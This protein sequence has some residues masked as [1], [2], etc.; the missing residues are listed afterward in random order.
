[1]DHYYAKVD[2]LEDRFINRLRK[3]I[4]IPSISAYASHRSDV[5]A[6][7]EFIIQEMTALGIEGRLRPLGKEPNTDLDLPPLVIGR[8]G[9]DPKKPTI[10]VYSHYDVQP[11]AIEDGW[12]RNPWD[13]TIE[14]DGT[15]HGRGTSDDKGPLLAWLNAIEAF[16]EAGVEVPANLVFCFEGMEENGSTGFRQTLEEEARTSLAD[17]DAV[18]ITDT[19][20]GGNSHPSIT[21]GLRGV[22]FY[23]LTVTG[24]KRDAHSGLFG[25]HLSEPMTDV[26]TLM[27]SLVDSTGR[28]LVPGIYEGV[29]EVSNSERAAIETLHLSAED[30]DP[31]LGGRNL[32]DSI[33]DTIIARSRLPS[34]SLHRIE[35]AMPGAGAVT[36]IP[37]KVQGKFSIRTVADMSAEHVNRLVKDHIKSE[38]KSLKSVNSAELVCV[39]KSNWFFEDVDHWNYQ[40]AKM[41]TK[42]VWNKEPDITCEGG[43]IPIALDLKE[44]LGKNVLLLPMGKPSDG[45]HSINEKLDKPN[46]LNGIKLFGS[47]LNQVSLLYS[48]NDAIRPRGFK[49]AEI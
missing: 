10:L 13:L 29:K 1:M 24:A 15:L 46:Y 36:S 27:S 16:Q 22:L 12:D 6:M 7:A 4:R 26:A 44:V 30:V 19:T 11:A 37:A 49:A 41:A 5:F 21:R 31:G 32:H 45:A 35:N 28:I 9:K 39:H 38:F 34:L 3:G 43:S 20:W 33:A 17:I 8:Y 47:Y 40:A 2:E 42:A 14:A 25:G 48:R 18:C 23:I